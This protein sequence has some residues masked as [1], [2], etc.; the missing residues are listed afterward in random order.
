MLESWNNAELKIEAWQRLP[1]GNWHC[2]LVLSP[3]FLHS[4]IPSF[5]YVST[6]I[7]YAV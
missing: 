1:T 5:Q 2:Q 7:H 3:S 4:S 6:G